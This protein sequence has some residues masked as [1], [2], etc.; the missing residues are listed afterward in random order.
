M[1]LDK[2]VQAILQSK[3][4]T[5]ED[6]YKLNEAVFNMPDED[7]VHPRTAKALLDA[8]RKSR[9]FYNSKAKK[10]AN[11]FYD[12]IGMLGTMQNQSFFS[13]KQYQEIIAML[14]E[15]SG[16][17]GSS[18]ASKTSTKE[19]EKLKQENEKLKAEVAKLKELRQAVQA[20]NG[21]VMP[22]YL[23]K[24]AGK[25]AKKGEGKGKKKEKKE[26]KPKGKGKGKAEGEKAEGEKAEGEVEAKTE[27]PSEEK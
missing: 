4:L 1:Y 23:A 24:G 20:I 22:A 18:Q 10:D 5:S 11:Y 16:T 26:K 13:E 21:F 6:L 12:F 19:A 7:R 8:I 27:A 14:N 3:K 2:V 15:A 25:G 9:D 17:G